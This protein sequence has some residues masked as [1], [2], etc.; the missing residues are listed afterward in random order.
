MSN[1]QGSTVD[2]EGRMRFMEVSEATGEA[3]R[4]FWTV[5]EPHLPAVLD[6]FYAHLGAVPE[7]AKLVGTQTPRSKQAQGAH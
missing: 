3:L 4:D 5:I 1:D 2:R 6:G 7:L